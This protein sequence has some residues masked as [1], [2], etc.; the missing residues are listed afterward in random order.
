MAEVRV[1]AAGGGTTEAVLTAV[2]LAEADRL[3]LL[4]LAPGEREPAQAVPPLVSLSAGILVLAGLTGGRVAVLGV[5]LGSAQEALPGERLEALLDWALREARGV[6]G[7]LLVLMPLAAFLLLV[8]LTS[9]VA[10]VVVYWGFTVRREGDRLVIERGLLGRRRAFIPLHRIQ[11]VR[12][13]ENILRRWLGLASAS[14][15]VAGYAQPGEE[16]ELSAMLLPL[17]EQGEAIDLARR[18]AGPDRPV[19]LE[20]PPVGALARRLIYALA[21]R[22]SGS[23]L[24]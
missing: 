12:V 9:L 8:L 10:T 1:E 23:W 13:H 4:L 24:C 22:W 6:A 17:A 14:L 2:S 15:V 11:A 7:I 20:L 18:L 16:R 3:R 5:I 21:V 19:T